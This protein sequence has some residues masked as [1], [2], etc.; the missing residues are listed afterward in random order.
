MTAGIFNKELHVK[1][2]LATVFRMPA[3]EWN[4]YAYILRGCLCEYVI[5]VEYLCIYFVVVVV[6]M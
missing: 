2:L 4:T 1:Y 6:N 5:R 3:L